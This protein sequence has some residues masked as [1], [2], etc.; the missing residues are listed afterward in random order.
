[1]ARLDITPFFHRASGSWTWLVACTTTRRAAV[2]DPVLDWDDSAEAI[3]FD[4][5]NAVLARLDQNALI[6]DYVLET[7]A[8]ADR[9]SASAYLKQRTGARVGIGAGIVAVQ[10]AYAN[11]H[12]DF[13][14]LADGGDFDLL[15]DPGASLPLGEHSIEVIATPGHTPD[16]VSYRI[17]DAVF[18]GDT[19]FAP[20][21]GSARADFPGA[22]AATLYRSI[23]RLLD[24]PSGTRLYL[25]HDYPSDQREPIGVINAAMTRRDNPHFV[26]ADERA[27]IELRRARDATL[28]TPQRMGIALPINLRAGKIAAI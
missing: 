11:A 19:L 7:H 20:D 18:I 6:L 2:I 12:G 8:H 3:G 10:R 24:L 1:M 4:A 28:P 13:G 16:G 23:T 25:C 21:A 5:A 15:L 22:D 27:Y 9:I 17:G 14:A 26:H